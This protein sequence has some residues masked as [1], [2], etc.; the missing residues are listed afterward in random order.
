MIITLSI[1]LTVL[2]TDDGHPPKANVTLGNF[3]HI[4]LISERK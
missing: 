1:S 2:A 4:Q 3:P